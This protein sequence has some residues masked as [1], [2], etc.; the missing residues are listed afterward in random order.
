MDVE[1]VE[2]GILFWLYKHKLLQERY[3]GEES[4][5]FKRWSLSLKQDIYVPGLRISSSHPNTA[6][7]ELVSWSDRNTTQE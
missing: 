4:H 7:D 2:L 5:V 1:M 3:V 6:F